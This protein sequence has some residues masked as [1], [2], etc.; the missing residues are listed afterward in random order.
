M[1]DSAEPPTRTLAVQLG[2]AP[3]PLIRGQRQTL[4]Q[5][6]I[7]RYQQAVAWNLQTI[8]LIVQGFCNL[9]NEI[10]LQSFLFFFFIFINLSFNSVPI[11]ILF[12]NYSHKERR[13]KCKKKRFKEQMTIKWEFVLKTNEN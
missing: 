5:W 1:S 10:R 2:A 11:F 7:S 3:V 9:H 6:L 12:E 13:Q 4:R 8:K